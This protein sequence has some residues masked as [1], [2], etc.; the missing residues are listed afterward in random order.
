MDAAQKAELAAK[1]CKDDP[2]LLLKLLQASGAYLADKE[3]AA[4][5]H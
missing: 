5:A 1:I 3:A 4:A 2:D